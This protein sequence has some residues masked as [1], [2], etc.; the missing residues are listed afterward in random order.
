MLP[1]N[2]TMVVYRQTSANHFSGV[3]VLAKT[4]LYTGIVCSVQKTRLLWW[5]FL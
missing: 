4:F 1:V 5:L 2:L 3:F